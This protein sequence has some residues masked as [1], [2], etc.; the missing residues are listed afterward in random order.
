MAIAGAKSFISQKAVALGEECIQ[1]HGGMGV[2]D[3]L[4]VGHAHKRILLLATLFGDSEHELR[5]YGLAV[6]DRPA[7]PE[8]A[9]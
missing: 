5:R 1:L 2:S 8:G 9:S 7:D 4:S 3:E 6:R